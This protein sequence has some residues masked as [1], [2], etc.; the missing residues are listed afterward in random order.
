M[1]DEQRR[2]LPKIRKCLD[3]AADT[4][5]NP[6]MRETAWRQAQALIQKHDLQLGQAHACG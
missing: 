3:L 2:V 4:R 6:T 1:N 5:G